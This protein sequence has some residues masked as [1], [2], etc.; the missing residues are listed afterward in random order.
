MKLGDTAE[1]TDEVGAKAAWGPP[2]AN[3][4]QQTTRDRTVY[5]APPV[6]EVGPGAGIDESTGGPN[7]VVDRGPGDELPAPSVKG[8]L[9]VSILYTG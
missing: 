6:A 9:H 5:Y 8:Q 1:P 2:N 4:R 3:V 7:V